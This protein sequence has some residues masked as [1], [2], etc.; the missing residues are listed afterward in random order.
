MSR[1]IR[2][3]LRAAVTT[4]QAC[5][6]AVWYV[7]RPRA[8]GVAAVPLTDPGT[9]VLVKLTYRAGWHLPAG[10]RKAG[11][12]PKDAILRELKEEIG[13]TRVRAVEWIGAMEHSPD[14]RRGTT[15]VFLIH[16]VQYSPARW[17]LEVE[18]VREFQLQALPGDLSATS[19]QQLRMAGL[20]V[21]A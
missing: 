7:T 6:R 2:S 3:L 8:L 10:G 1:L 12:R 15:E 13:L 9:V 17:S 4:F 21:E 5:R 14:F 19:R 20:L 18:E 16:D 11:E